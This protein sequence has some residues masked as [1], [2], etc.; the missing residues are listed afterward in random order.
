MEDITKIDIDQFVKDHPEEN[1]MSA[2]QIAHIR[3][4]TAKSRIGRRDWADVEGTLAGH[5]LFVLRPVGNV[6]FVKTVERFL[7]DGKSL[8]L[9]TNLA[10]CRSYL[11]MLLQQHGPGDWKIEI[12]STT[13][14]EAMVFVQQHQLYAAIDYTGQRETKA[15]LYSG[16]D[17]EWLS[18]LD[19]K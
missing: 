5:S 3:I 8:I 12:A 9:F 15:F 7:V 6:S 11:N 2:D 14:P 13:L 18:S 19:M 1:F 10:D 16:K 17:R 4:K